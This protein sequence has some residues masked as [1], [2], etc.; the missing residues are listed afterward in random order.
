MKEQ[1]LINYINKTIQLTP[2]EAD[3]LLS[4]IEIHKY[5]KGDFIVKEGRV[6]W[7]ICFVLSG[8]TKNYYHDNDGNEKIVQFAIEDWWTGDLGSYLSKTSADFNVEC[9]EDTEVIRFTSEVVDSIMDSIP[10]FER[11]LRINTE[12]ALV[13]SQ[14]RV[15]RL[16]NWTAK[17]RYLLFLKQY[18]KIEQR[19]PQYM[20][21]SYLGV[22]KEFF[23]KMKKEILSDM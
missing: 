16:T 2:E 21:A 7:F 1:R 8:C 12:Q 3:V 19:I 11:F 13:A 22:T 15:I 20:V 18:P 5:S 10:K 17:D 4:K 6:C 14:K 9:L 23:S